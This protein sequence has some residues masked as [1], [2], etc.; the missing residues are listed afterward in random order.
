MPATV[1]SGGTATNT[2]VN[3][4]GFVDLFGGATVSGLTVSAGAVVRVD[5]AWGTPIEPDRVLDAAR[6]A[7][8]K[9]IAA[10]HAETS[11]GVRNDIATATGPKI[12]T[13]ATVDAGSTLVSSV[14]G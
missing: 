7:K 8:A 5:A 6:A 9:L 12:S 14:G 11:T 13:C 1:L 2:T 3:R 4:G 10:V